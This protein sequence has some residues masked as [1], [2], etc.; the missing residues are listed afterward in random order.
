MV[1]PG[2]I[3]GCLHHCCFYFQ[4]NR[5]WSR[6]VRSGFRSRN[7]YRRY[8]LASQV[9]QKAPA[10]RLNFPLGSI[11]QH[12]HSRS[13]SLDVVVVLLLSSTFL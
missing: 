6:S 2:C 1:I 10:P 5:I 9:P 12:L 3:L 11:S 7:G 4:E 13:L 8:I